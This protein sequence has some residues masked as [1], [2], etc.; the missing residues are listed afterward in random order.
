MVHLY[1]Y[2][3][4]YFETVGTVGWVTRMAS[5][6]TYTERLMLELAEEGNKEESGCNLGSR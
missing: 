2:F 5:S 4:Q 3:F 1:F 6:S